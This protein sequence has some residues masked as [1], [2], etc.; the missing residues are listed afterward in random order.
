[1]EWRGIRNQYKA[2]LVGSGGD[3]F[4]RYASD[5]LGKYGVDFVLCENIYLAVGQLGKCSGEDIIV[6]GRLGELSREN[7]RFFEIAEKSKVR[8]LCLA[9]KDSLIERKQI[10]VATK[11]GAFVL[12]NSAGLKEALCRL[13]IG[14]RAVSSERKENKSG[15]G[16]DRNKFFTT[17]AELDALLGIEINEKS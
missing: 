13:S 5:L 4:V 12:H 9:E 7:G 6:V 17:K 2:I 11:N 1:M 15:S 14:E 8:C 10:S 16:F 3:E